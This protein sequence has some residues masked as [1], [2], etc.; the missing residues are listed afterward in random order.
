MSTHWILTRYPGKN[1]ENKKLHFDAVKSPQG[2]ALLGGGHA[3]VHPAERGGHA[4]VHPAEP[5]I[6]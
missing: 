6:Q 1:L 3:A 5:Y 2:G 4:A